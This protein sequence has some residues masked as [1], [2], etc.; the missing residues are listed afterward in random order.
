M[1]ADPLLRL[2]DPGPYERI[3]Q[4]CGHRSE[5][6]G[7]AATSSSPTDKDIGHSVHALGGCSTPGPHS[8]GGGLSN[9]LHLVTLVR[10]GAAFEEGKRVERPIGRRRRRVGPSEESLIRDDG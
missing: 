10:A 3:A 7:A 4:F 9:A 8:P 5:V 6:R 2:L 1:S